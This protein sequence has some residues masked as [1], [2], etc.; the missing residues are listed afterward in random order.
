MATT[1]GRKFAFI[2]NQVELLNPFLVEISRRTKTLPRHV[3]YYEPCVFYCPPTM[4][5]ILKS[6]LLR[7]HQSVVKQSMVTV[8]QEAD[9]DIIGSESQLRTIAVEAIV[10]AVEASKTRNK[11]TRKQDLISECRKLRAKQVRDEAYLQATF[12]E[13]V[14]RSLT[15]LK[16]LASSPK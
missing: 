14:N 5:I 4:T 12:S 10:S 6:S 1:S 11:R 9:P 13:D 2:V 3:A 7:Y 15:E 16:F 8:L